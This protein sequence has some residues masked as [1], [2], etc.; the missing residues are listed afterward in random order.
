MYF[1][2][3]FAALGVILVAA[4]LPFPSKAQE[5]ARETHAEVEKTLGFVPGCRAYPEHGVAAA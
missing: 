5:T 4:A 2:T 1:R 3:V